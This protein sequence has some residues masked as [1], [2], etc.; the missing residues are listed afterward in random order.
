MASFGVFGSSN[1]WQCKLKF[2]YMKNPSFGALYSLFPSLAIGYQ[3]NHRCKEENQRK[4]SNNRHFHMIM[5]KFRI[6]WE[7]LEEEQLQDWV[8]DKFR[9]PCETTRGSQRISYTMR[10]FAWYA[11]SSCAPTPLD[12]YLQIFC[13]ISYFLLVI[14]LDIFF[15]YFFISFGNIFGRQRDT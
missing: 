8:K 5:R 4:K 12:F 2:K 10:N 14:N 1:P 15:L 3:A 9:I 7:N 13:V 11:K 6:A